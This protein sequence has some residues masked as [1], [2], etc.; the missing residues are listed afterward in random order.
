MITTTEQV[1]RAM[2][3]A[4]RDDAPQAIVESADIKAWGENMKRLECGKDEVPCRRG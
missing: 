2:L 3:R 1:G 4:A